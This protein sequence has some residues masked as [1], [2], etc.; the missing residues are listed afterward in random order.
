[1]ATKQST[2]LRK[3]SD[4]LKAYKRAVRW[5]KV[6]LAT[7]AVV[8]VGLLLWAIPWLPYGLAVEDY[9]SRLTLLVGLVLAASTSAFGTI[10]HRDLSRRVEQTM[11]T[12]STVHDGLTD[13]RRREYFFDRIVIEC[14]RA[15]NIGSE[16]TVIALRT[17][18]E[19]E[20]PSEGA[21]ESAL[22]ALAPVVKD[23]DCLAALGPREI[24][25]LARVHHAEAAGF[26]E[27]LRL[28]L[29]A[30][31]RDATV[32]RAGWSVYRVDSEEAGTLVG[33][34]RERVLGKAQA[35]KAASATAEHDD[36]AYISAARAA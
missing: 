19:T 3:S 17:G 28:L 26:A 24:G 1:M 10:Y 36:D 5:R 31:A 16:F 8:F 20:A 7:F 6:M 15:R 13:M 2:D 4:L 11:L 35:A 18:D 30:T 25:V 9:D 12:W 14:E 33:L 23:Y 27:K 21:N 29:A 32:V 22:F 34:A